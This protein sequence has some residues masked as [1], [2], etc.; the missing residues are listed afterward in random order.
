MTRPPAL[1]VAAV[2]G[3][4]AAGEIL[5]EGEIGLASAGSAAVPHVR[6]VASQA[7]REQGMDTIRPAALDRDG[8]LIAFVARDRG[9]SLQGCCQNVY[10]LERAT[11]Q[12]TLESAGP[13]GARPNGDSQRPTLSWDGRILAFETL[14]SN[15]FT[16][17]PQRRG[18]H[19]VIRDRAQGVW[20]TPSGPQGLEPDGE[21]GDAVVAGNGTV[22]VFT[23]DA[24]NLVP[25][26]DANGPR[27]DVYRWR[28]EDSSI[29]RV[30]VDTA[31]AQASA[32]A[33][34]GP[35]VSHDGELVAFVSTSR[36]SP[37]DTNDVADV[38][39][40]DLRRGVTSL[41]SRGLG[42]KPA[43]GPSHS[44]ALSADGRHLAFASAARNLV[45]GDRNGERDVFVYDVAAGSIALASA[46]A[47]GGAANAASGAPA[48]SA[49][50]RHVVFQSAASNLGSGP[51]C[52][53]SVPDRNLLP[54]VYLLDRT[55]GCMTRISGSPDQDWWAP[56]VAPAIDAAG[57]IVV[58][59]TTQ[60]GDGDD[61]GTDFD[62]FL[63]RRPEQGSAAIT[64][65]PCPRRGCG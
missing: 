10:I 25:G 38:Y 28:L 15:F 61:P 52:P 59:S 17:H 1:A 6:V 44:P 45:R 8:R 63:F 22:V 36:L 57:A 47:A 33:S 3:A 18:R 39:L 46:T 48:I 29:A 13:D 54:D 4:C 11:G 2:A 40:R 56:S 34:H 43:D 42:G 65:S 64:G 53:P 9:P 32:G 27:T 35:S 30:S 49:G 26:W 41:V 62:L 19:F 7:I 20:R 50:G 5:A 21:T 31:G 60:P 23:A 16:G 37:D 12:I 58:F 55:S 14:A 51:G 24:T